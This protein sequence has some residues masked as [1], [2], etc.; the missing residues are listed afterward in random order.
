MPLKGP[1]VV[2]MFVCFF[3]VV[4]Q[5]I[6]KKCTQI[7]NAWRTIVAVIKAFVL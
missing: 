6:A 5:I 7:Y 4:L 3:A 2:L 1:T